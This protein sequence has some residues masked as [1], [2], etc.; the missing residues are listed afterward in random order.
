LRL[1]SPDG[2]YH[3]RSHPASLV[4]ETQDTADGDR[5]RVRIKMPMPGRWRVFPVLTH[6]FV[7]VDSDT[8]VALSV[9]GQSDVGLDV[10]LRV[11]EGGRWLSDF[12][13]L[14][15]RLVLGRPDGTLTEYDGQ[16]GD[17]SVRLIFDDIS[18][19]GTYHVTASVCGRRCAR[20]T[21][22]SFQIGGRQGI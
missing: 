20:Q 16:P 22:T 9:S 12:D 18:A 5:Q 8:D 4:W 2:V 7:S 3:S 15:P 13:H 17:G 14:Q 6:A 19:P 10:R 11:R 21:R 1:R